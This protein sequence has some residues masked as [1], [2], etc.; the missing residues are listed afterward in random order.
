M[1]KAQDCWFAYIMYKALQLPFASRWHKFPYA[2]PVLAPLAWELDLL[3]VISE[4][5]DVSGT[6]TP[7]C[8]DLQCGFLVA[9]G[10]SYLQLMFTHHAAGADAEVTAIPGLEPLEVFLGVLERASSVVD[11]SPDPLA[12]FA[13]FPGRSACSC[14]SSKHMSG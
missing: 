2:H 4:F 6:V 8:T 1:A 14:R 3:L 7:G 9:A 13:G 11:L 5:P 12:L 10:L